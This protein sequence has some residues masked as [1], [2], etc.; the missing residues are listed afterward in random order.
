MAVPVERLAEQHVEILRPVD[1]PR[2]SSGFRTAIAP[3]SVW[4]TYRL[5]TGASEHTWE[6]AAS[7]YR[8]LGNGVADMDAAGIHLHST[9]P[10]DM[11]ATPEWL[12]TL[13]EKYA[14]SSW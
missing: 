1:Q 13:I 4:I 12:M 3:Y 11:E 8:V 7:G 5:E 2:L 6:A 10:F 9:N 14:P